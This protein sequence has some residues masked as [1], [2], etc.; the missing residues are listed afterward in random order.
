MLI[1]VDPSVLV[2]PSSKSPL[3]VEVGCTWYTTVPDEGK[4]FPVKSDF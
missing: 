1:P 3:V 4:A 2:D